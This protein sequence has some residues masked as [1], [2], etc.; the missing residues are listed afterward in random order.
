[1]RDVPAFLSH[2]RR[3]RRGLPVPFI[4]RWGAESTDRLSIEHDP[5]VGQLAIF[6]YDNHEPEPDFLHQNMQRQ[7]KCM[8][9]GW[10]QVCARPMP[11]SR[12][13][14][15]VSSM[16][17]EQVQVAGR[18]VA[19]VTEPWLDE[20]CAEFALRICPGL[21]RRRTAHGLTL[22]PVTSKR[23]VQLVVSNG[24]VEGHLEEESKRIQPAMWAK[25]ALIGV[26]I[27]CQ[28]RAS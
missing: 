18:P 4:N 16:S 17:V 21:I 24:W 14:L 27:E 26:R 19:V 22:V 13:F 9:L 10:C 5:N 7:R 8:T 25:V 15:V 11:W 12:R 6:D 3:D 2:L 28:E 20:R 1:V 23:E